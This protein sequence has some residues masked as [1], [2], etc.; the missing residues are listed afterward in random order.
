VNDHPEELIRRAA[1]G[2]PKNAVIDALY[3]LKRFDHLEPDKRIMALLEHGNWQVEWESIDVLAKMGGSEVERALLAYGERIDDRNLLPHVNAT[4]GRIGG[5]MSVAYLERR[6][7][8]PRDDVACSA[9]W[10]L[11]D[12]DGPGHVDLFIVVLESA[13]RAAIK[14]YATNA[15]VRHAGAE[16]VEP[17]LARLR[18]LLA[19]K[20]TIESQP[21]EV[22]EIVSF[23]REHAQPG[24]VAA[25]YVTSKLPARA[26]F[27]LPNERIELADL[28]HVA[29]E[30]A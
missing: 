29:G 13:R 8:D 14:S 27:L 5:P 4:L 12:I 11:A 17:L 15:I 10:A 23:L 16:A 9:I 20:R 19:R 2:R 28:L 24:S 26:D 6:C 7:L 3:A 22:V 18:Q 25:D 30:P 1:A 21:S